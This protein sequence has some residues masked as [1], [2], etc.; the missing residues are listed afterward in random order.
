[1]TE[2]KPEIS[3]AIMTHP[4]RLED[5]EELR[6]QLATDSLSVE[7][8]TD[9]RPA[10]SE[11]ATLPT[12]LS[13]W[14]AMPESATHHLVLQDDVELCDGFND[15]LAD[16]VEAID[17]PIRLFSEWG[18]TTATAVRWAALSGRAAAQC[19]DTYTPTQ[20]VLLSRDDVNGLVEFA[21]SRSWN[22]PDDIVLRE[23]LKQSGRSAFALSPNLL[24]H[25]GGSNSLMHN[26][27]MGPRRATLQP[28]EAALAGD[29]LLALDGWVPTCTCRS[30][31]SP[32]GSM[33][34]TTAPRPGSASATG[35]R[36]ARRCGGC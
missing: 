15:R 20:G 25:D 27:Q 24:E 5:A 13:A 23:Y 10:G 21:E 14:S 19:V 28:S 1:M 36:P 7:V 9:P 34:S 30:R 31:R 6:E 35:C 18:S 26:E 17:E 32:T 29:G 3:C 33:T 2:A 8:V 4:K 12:S 11:P 16:A 22:E